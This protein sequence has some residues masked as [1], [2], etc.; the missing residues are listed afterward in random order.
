[1]PPP[2]PAMSLVSCHSA[3]PCSLPVKEI[4]ALYISSREFASHLPMVRCLLNVELILQACNS[5]VAC[6]KAAVRVPWL[7]G[8][9]DFRHTRVVGTLC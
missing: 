6:Q 4:C 9:V 5:Q 1:M 3:V 8:C 7:M 2:F